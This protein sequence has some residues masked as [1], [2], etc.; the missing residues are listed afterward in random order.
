MFSNEC[1]CISRALVGGFTS[2]MCTVGNVDITGTEN[3][4]LVLF[5]TEDW[6]RGMCNLFTEMVN[7]ELV[8]FHCF[9][10]N[11]NTTRELDF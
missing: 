1:Q 6:C 7:K 8:R 5:A 2:S 3:L 11:I 10:Q 4:M 9:C